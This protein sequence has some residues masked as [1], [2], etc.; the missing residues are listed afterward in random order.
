MRTVSI[1][2][3]ALRTLCVGLFG[4]RSQSPA[5]RVDGNDRWAAI[6]VALFAA[7]GEGVT[8]FLQALQINVEGQGWLVAAAVAGVFELWRRRQ[9]NY[10]PPTPAPPG[11]G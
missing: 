1:I 10:Q 6:R 8:A 5:G 7:F 9:R 2:S 4:G 3:L 11:A